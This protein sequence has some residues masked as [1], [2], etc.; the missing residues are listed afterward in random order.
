MIGVYKYLPGKRLRNN[1]NDE[2]PKQ[3][4]VNAPPGRSASA[5]EVSGEKE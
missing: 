2:E 3:G 1:K 5:L 4:V